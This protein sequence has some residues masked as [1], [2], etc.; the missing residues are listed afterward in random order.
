VFP[1]KK[2]IPKQNKTFASYKCTKTNNYTTTK[3]L[4]E[5]YSGS[6]DLSCL[7]PTVNSIKGRLGDTVDAALADG[8]ADNNAVIA[9]LEAQVENIAF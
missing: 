7:T 8:L 4:K 1:S 2:P 5:F 9:Q 3:K 6:D